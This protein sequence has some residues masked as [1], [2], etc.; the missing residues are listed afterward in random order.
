MDTMILHL[1]CFLV[2]INFE[3]IYYNLLVSIKIMSLVVHIKMITPI[4]FSCFN[5]EKDYENCCVQIRVIDLR[6][7]GERL[8]ACLLC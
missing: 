2:F 1:F 4:N 7:G 3:V 5:Y 6:D 8:R